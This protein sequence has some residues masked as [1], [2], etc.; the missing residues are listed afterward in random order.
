MSDQTTQPNV[1]TVKTRIP[2]EPLGAV[3]VGDE[4][5]EGALVKKYVL[6]RERTNERNV[7][8]RSALAAYAECTP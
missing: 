6:K 7:N 1:V 2:Q 5:M 3:F 4:N 8:S